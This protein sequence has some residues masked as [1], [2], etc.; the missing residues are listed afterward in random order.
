[1][2]RSVAQRSDDNLHGAATIIFRRELTG[3]VPFRAFETSRSLTN[4]IQDTLSV[5]LRV[6][7]I[8]S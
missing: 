2:L 4:I 1:M 3:S 5:L 7:F 8:P 6:V